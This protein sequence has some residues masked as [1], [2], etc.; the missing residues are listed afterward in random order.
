MP[1]EKLAATRPELSSGESE[2]RA[3]AELST[4]GST[5]VIVRFLRN[6]VPHAATRSNREKTGPRTRTDRHSTTI[7]RGGGGGCQ[8]GCLTLDC[9]CLSHRRREAATAP[10]RGSLIA[11]LVMFVCACGVWLSTPYIQ[12]GLQHTLHYRLLS[13]FD[14]GVVE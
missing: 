14:V 6:D 2:E 8:C 13:R 1:T 9:A 5:M 3:S 10:R 4:T 12:T 7:S 11:F